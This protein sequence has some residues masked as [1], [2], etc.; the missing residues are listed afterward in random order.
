MGVVCFLRRGDNPFPKNAD[1]TVKYDSTH[2][3]ETWKALEALVAK[4]L[5]KALGLSN[6]SSRQIDDVLSVA[7]VRP[8]VLQVSTTADEWKVYCMHSASGG[9]SPQWRW[10]CQKC[11]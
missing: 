10:Q 11:C 6:F 4:G 8:A 9:E 5:V 7:S 2:Y 1:G 3:K